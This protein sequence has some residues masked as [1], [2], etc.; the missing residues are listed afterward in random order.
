M[1][2]GMIILVAVAV[3]IYLGAAQRVLD[4]LRLTDRAALIFVGAMVAGGFLP[5]IPLSEQLSINIGGGI[6]PAALAV[7]LL[8]KA[9]AT[10]EKIRAAAA[11]VAAAAAVYAAMKIMPT[12]PTYNYLMDPMYL[13]AVIAAV[14]GYL[15]GRSRRSAFIAGSM[16]LL[17]TDVFS[18]I[19]L[20]V[21]GGS[22][23]MSIG[24]AGVFD[25]IVIGGILA[26]LLAEFF[27]ETR[28]RIQG[29]PA[30]DRP[31][32]LK[33]GLAGGGSGAG[34]GSDEVNQSLED[35]NNEKK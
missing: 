35:D 20:A 22:G 10:R 14:A 7:Y 5:E 17:L 32:S 1:T 13:F 21:R 15:A 27:G 12:E 26:L 31:E 16:G 34:W 18:R 6:V 2:I 25:S 30:E 23:R 29:G 4:R 28:E 33:K 24:G 8:V 11:S 19:E 3:L 9:G